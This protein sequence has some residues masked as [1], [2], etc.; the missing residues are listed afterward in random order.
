MDDL[1]EGCIDDRGQMADERQTIPL[2][3]NRYPLTAKT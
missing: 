3:P 1:I 2:S